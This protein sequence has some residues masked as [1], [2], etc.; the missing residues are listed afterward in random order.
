MKSTKFEI[1]TRIAPAILV[2]VAAYFPVNVVHY[3]LQVQRTSFALF[4][5]LRVKARYTYSPADTA[6]EP[7]GRHKLACGA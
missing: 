5:T 4:D 3:W 6:W 2:S 7:F 1:S